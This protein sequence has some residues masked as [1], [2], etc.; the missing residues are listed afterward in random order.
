MSKVSKL[1]VYFGNRLIGTMALYKDT[2][3][4]FEYSKD[5]LNFLWTFCE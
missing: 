1:D 5:W 3:A 2:L 4:A